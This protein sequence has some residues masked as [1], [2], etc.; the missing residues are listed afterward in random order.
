MADVWV[1]QGDTAPGLRH[2][3]L[4]GEGNAVNL[5]NAAVVFHMKPMRGTVADPISR[6]AV[7][8]QVSDG[9][10]GSKGDVHVEWED[11]DLDVPGGYFGEW[12]VTFQ[13][14]KVE[15]FPNDHN[16]TIAV[17]EQLA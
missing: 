11:G 15:S 13:D 6:T 3:L 7:I 8:D 5:L 10:D 4:D 9:S 17:V 16:F 12:E 14:T 2:T 1:K